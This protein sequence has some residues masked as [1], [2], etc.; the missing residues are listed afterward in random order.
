M[1]DE[2]VI[3]LAVRIRPIRIA[4]VTAVEKRSIEIHL[5]QHLP[6]IASHPSSC[7]RIRTAE[8]HWMRKSQ[9]FSYP[10]RRPCGRSCYTTGGGGTAVSLSSNVFT[11]IFAFLQREGSS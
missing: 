7:A 9:D 10:R 6:A 4:K 8:P 11:V 2:I 5:I 1:A 3:S